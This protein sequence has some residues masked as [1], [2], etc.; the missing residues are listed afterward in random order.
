MSNSFALRV[1]SWIYNSILYEE[2]PN[3]L[4]PFNINMCKKL[5]TVCDLNPAYVNEIFYESY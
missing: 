1:F 4:L 5:F 3:F 2:R